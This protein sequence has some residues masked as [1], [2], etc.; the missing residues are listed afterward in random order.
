[1]AARKANQYK[2][3]IALT[4]IWPHPLDKSLTDLLYVRYPLRTDSTVC[5]GAN[6]TR[7]LRQIMGN[8]RFLKVSFS[9]M[10]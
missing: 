2:M 6:S 7:T 5:K 10:S 9:D 1:M 8:K 4:D 3:N